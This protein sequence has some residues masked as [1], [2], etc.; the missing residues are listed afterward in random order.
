[1]KLLIIY[2]EI[3]WDFLD[4]RHHH[5]ARYAAKNGYK[6]EFVE[7]VVS[8]VPAL[9]D[10]IRVFIKNFFYKKNKYLIKEIPN[11]VSIRKSFFLPPVI[12]FSG[13]YNWLVWFF[14]ERQRQ[15]NAIIYSFVNNPYIIGGNYSFLAKHS[16]SVF[17]IIHNWWEFLWHKEKQKRIVNKNI[18]LYNKVITDSPAIAK[19]LESSNIKFHMMLPGM[20]SDWLDI[21][22]SSN[23]YIKPVFYGNLRSNSDLTL[24]NEFIEEYDLHLIGI[25]NDFI[26]KDLKSYT[27][28]GQKN[29]KELLVC[30]KS[31]NLILLPYNNDNFSKTIAPAKYFEALAT[32]SLVVTCA[33]L[34]HLPGFTEFVLKID[35]SSKDFIENLKKAFS[36]QKY[37]RDVQVR[38][39]SKH[40]WQ[41]RFKD[42]FIYLEKN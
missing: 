7:R 23:S 39:A 9:K 2:S 42:L 25:I 21:S 40:S 28:L 1:M 29:E 37:K 8:R 35:V 33:D 32:G 36:N 38:F 27:Y 41:E 10:L 12:L 26:K 13:I 11:G 19:K 14:H 15:K 22:S 30:M 31:Y 34:S 16:L 24:V 20:E 6:V 5:L 17:D 18:N 4:Q 3:T